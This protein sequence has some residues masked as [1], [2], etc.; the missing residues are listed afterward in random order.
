MRHNKNK[1][2]IPESKLISNNINSL[3]KNVL[4]LKYKTSKLKVML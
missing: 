4:N 3:D 2:N 1:D